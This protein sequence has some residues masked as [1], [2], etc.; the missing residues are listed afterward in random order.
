MKI[1]IPKGRLQA[2][3][4]EALAGVDTLGGIHFPSQRGYR[5]ASKIPGIEAV[6][7]KPR[8]I[9]QLLQLRCFDI[10]FCGLDILCE[11]GEPDVIS[12]LDLGLNPV[13]IVVA[14][15]VSK[16]D[17]LEQPPKRPLVIATE[18]PNLAAQ[19]AFKRNLACIT[20]QT[21]GGTEAYVPEIA[22]IVIDCVETGA[23][24]E[25]NGLVRIEELFRSTT[26][27]VAN[28]VSQFDEEIAEIAR[29]MMDIPQEERGTR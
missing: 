26:H 27:M 13:H 18:Y 6:L 16:R 19:W 23:T 14:V 2:P 17:I 4:L 12:A 11:A 28:G 22:D 5:G 25:A 3:V 10:G 7:I 20:V 24:L 9:P 29:Q 15:P 21:Y 1:A 8:A